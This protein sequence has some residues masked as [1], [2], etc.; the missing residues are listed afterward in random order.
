MIIGN[1]MV[2]KGFSSYRDVE[3]VVIF[4]KGVSNSKETKL[5]SFNRERDELKL[6]LEQNKNSHFVYF[7]TCSIYDEDLN[8]S[9]YTVHKLKMEQLI[10]NSGNNFNIFRLPQVVGHT[11]NET[12]VNF[13]KASILKR[14]KFTVLKYAKRNLIDIE[15]VFKICSFIINNKIFLNSITNIATKE[16]TSVIQI[17]KSI[18]E[19]L[20]EEA[21]YNIVNSGSEYDIDV[22]R[23]EPVLKSISLKTTPVLQLLQKYLVGSFPK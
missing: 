4:A 23:I 11:N 18:E 13:F 19:V 14:E 6:A 12:L 1:G 3:N 9:Q 20:G 5:E 17:V 2:A 7:S 10:E 22:T 16:K 15:D 21:I 8:D